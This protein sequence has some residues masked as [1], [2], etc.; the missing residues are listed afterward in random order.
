MMKGNEGDKILTKFQCD[1]LRGIAIIGIF[2]HN[3]CHWLHGAI[4]ENEYDFV[5]E[6]SN[7]MWHYFNHDIDA[8][9][10]LQF[11]SFFGHYGVPIFLFLSGFGLVMKY[12]RKGAQPIKILSFL[13]YYWLK[14]FRLMLLGYMIPTILFIFMGAKPQTWNEVFAQLTLVVNMCFYPNPGEAMPSGCGPYWF[15][16]LML[17]VYV[18]YRLFIY[19]SH[20]K[21]DS[22]LRWLSP[23]LLILIAWA[24][25]EFFAG[26]TD[27]I[28]FLRYNV[29]IAA[30]PF[31]L[32][33]LV[34]RYD[35]P[36]LPR[37]LWG[38][39]SVLCL[40][41]MAVTNLNF[42]AW[43]WSP[44]VVV[45]GAVSFIKFLEKT[46]GEC[47][48]TNVVVVRPLVWVGALSSFIF[49]MHP[50]VRL[51]LFKIIL[52]KHD[53]L[54]ISDYLWIVVYIV[55]TLVLACFYRWLLN[56]IP[57]PNV[58]SKTGK[59]IIRK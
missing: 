45:L 14:L 6:N 1:A 57:S 20:N 24:V 47:L 50:V 15:F 21:D 12:E 22:V 56:Y 30:L 11:L 31:G 17:E 53:A 59:I 27:L 36:F 49:V 43:L 18:V 2:L 29:V 55:G 40:L 38:C 39:L 10:P 58:D 42:H 52:K 33:V 41:A 23:I 7:K 54:M 5:A 25:Q 4:K 9:A 28:H 26:N 46:S 35:I 19:P 16:G 34:G 13:G 44:V 32:G 8:F 3:F 37:W 48:F 51:P